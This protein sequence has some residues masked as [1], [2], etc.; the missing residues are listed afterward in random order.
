[1]IPNSLVN[2]WKGD[3]I[4]V[5]L[6]KQFNKWCIT[7]DIIDGG[8]SFQFTSPRRNKPLCS[9]ERLAHIL[10]RILDNLLTNIERL[11]PNTST[12]SLGILFFG[13]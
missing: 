12:A 1:M 5:I 6:N 9:R 4:D 13:V 3:V 11:H 2:T 7:M 10:D 8:E